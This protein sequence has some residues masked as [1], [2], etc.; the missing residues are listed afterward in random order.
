MALEEDGAHSDERGPQW[1]AQRY[2]TSFAERAARGPSV[3]QCGSW[4]PAAVPPR[5][6]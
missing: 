6:G 4:S 3:S 2:P 1:P 5:L